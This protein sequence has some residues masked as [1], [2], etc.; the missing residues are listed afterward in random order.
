M[1]KTLKLMICLFGLATFS[2]AMFGGNDAR[3][4]V[5]VPFDFVAGSTR[6]PAGQYTVREAS[7]NGI[8]F[9]TNAAGSAVALITAPGNLRSVRST[10]G[11][12]FDRVAGAPHLSQI[13]FED[14]PSRLVRVK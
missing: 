3:L 14:Q 6:L 1:K 13:T 7:E 12:S 9:I 10:T 11:L 8:V 5:S 2:G 4:V